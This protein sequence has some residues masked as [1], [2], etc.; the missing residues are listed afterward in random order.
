[1]TQE[2]ERERR[3][4][5]RREARMKQLIKRR[6]RRIAMLL[7]AL[8]LVIFLFVNLV[9]GI[10]G[11]FVKDKETKTE[12]QYPQD[13][14]YLAKDTGAYWQIP[15][16]DIKVKKPTIDVQLLTINPYSRSGHATNRITNI[17]IHYT[18][19]PGTTAQQNR[20]YFESLVETKEGSASSNYVVGLEGEI[21]QCVPT[22]EVAYASNQANPY[23]V[24]I[25]TCHIDETGEFNNATYE[26][27]VQLT[28]WLCAK[29]DLD[30]T[31]VIRHYDVTGKECP[32]YFVE[33]ELEWEQFK[34]R[35]KVVLEDAK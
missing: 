12:Y 11:V 6:R 28:A 5:I 33:N 7:A 2:T 18:G 32:K 15:D 16:E 27:L 24:S 29:F 17:V 34:A 3:L 22:N 9:N 20:D 25:E 4:R 21:I 19:N 26:S 13:Y 14:V 35:V 1:M 10:I 23:S 31:D 30:E 8:V